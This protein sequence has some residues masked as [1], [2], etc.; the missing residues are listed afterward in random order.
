MPLYASETYNKSYRNYLCVMRM[1]ILKKPNHPLKMIV[2]NEYSFFFQ[3]N[4]FS[5]PCNLL[6]HFSIDMFEMHFPTHPFAAA[7]HA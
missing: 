2:L 6:P 1:T 7:S 4:N 3:H 5:V